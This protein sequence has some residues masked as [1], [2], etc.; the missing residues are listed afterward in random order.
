MWDLS[1]ENATI[2]MNDPSYRRAVFLRDPASRLLSAYL[3]KFVN[4]KIGGVGLPG[5]ITFQQMINYLEEMSTPE[6]V[7]QYDTHWRPQLVQCNLEKFLPLFDIIGSQE[8]L[9]QHARI[10]LKM[11]ALWEKYGKRGWPTA[12]DEFLPSKSRAAHYT[13]ADNY[14]RSMYTQEMLLQVH[15]IYHED[16][17]PDLRG[18]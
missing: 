11:S 4:E 16:Y 3:D 17:Q 1:P 12:Q 2:I 18:H 13:G 15:E 8:N 14:V 7:R 9:S 10:L 6:E 5:N